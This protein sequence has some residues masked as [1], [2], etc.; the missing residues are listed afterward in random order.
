MKSR[1]DGDRV[2]EVKKEPCSEGGWHLGRRGGQRG[3]GGRT[4]G[5]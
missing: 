1:K 4:K 5:T 3:W 2:I